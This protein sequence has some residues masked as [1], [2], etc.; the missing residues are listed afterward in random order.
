MRFL[1]NYICKPLTFIGALNWG[2]IGIFG[3]DLVAWV[4]GNGTLLTNLIYAIVGISAL[5]WLVWDLID[6]K[7]IK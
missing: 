4:F 1:V 6:G 7:V 5:V 2:A 3:F